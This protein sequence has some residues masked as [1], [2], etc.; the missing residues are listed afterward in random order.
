MR[1][2]KLE[3][4]GRHFFLSAD[5][6]VRHGA[7]FLYREIDPRRNIIWRARF[8]TLQVYDVTPERAFRK[9]LDYIDAATDLRGTFK[10]PK[11]KSNCVM[12]A[13]KKECLETFYDDGDT[14]PYCRGCWELFI[15]W[16][17][18]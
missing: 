6:S 1:E 7:F 3:I 4:L 8:R 11:A 10:H 15:D 18:T 14:G 13:T 12:C 2:P 16:R 5:G 9:L 17:N